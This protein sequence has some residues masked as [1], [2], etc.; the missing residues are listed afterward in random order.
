[1]NIIKDYLEYNKGNECPDNY[2]IWSLFAVLSSVVNRKVWLNMAAEGE[3]AYFHVYANLY[4]CLVGRQG[5]RKTT[6]KD[7]AYDLLRK[8]W[9]ELPV[10]AESMS[11]EAITLYMSDAKQLRAFKLPDGNLVEYHP[12]SMF[13]TELKNFLSINP[14][15][16][17]DFLTTIYDRKFYDVKTKNK[18]T[19]TIVN[20]YV[21]MLACE[22][23]EWIVARLKESVISGGFSRRTIFVYETDERD[24][25]PFPSVSKASK[26]ALDR[27]EAHLRKLRDVSGEFQWTKEARDFYSEWYINLKFPEDPIMYGY[28]KS[29]H[30]QLMKIA[31]LIALCTGLELVLTKEHLEVGLAFLNSIEKNMPS[32]SQGVGRNEL[33]APTARMMM[34]I[35]TMGGLIA[36]KKLQSLMFKDMEPR[37]YEAVMKHL[38]ATDQIARAPFVTGGVTRMTV[39][40][41][42]K[43]DDLL[44][45]QKNRERQDPPNQT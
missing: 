17:I 43:Y 40:T 33:A 6:A 34:H 12:F 16:M 4:I 30:I 44:R 21:V 36:E 15:T 20:P 7:I 24:R 23:P 5:N 29:K 27:V 32:L 45:I 39:F 9:P 1:M 14:V 42:A 31:M 41:R 25:I 3:D 11:K 37:E 38:E 26:A 28:Y 35:E 8:V 22:T 10:S 2:H 19:D 18:G 13:I